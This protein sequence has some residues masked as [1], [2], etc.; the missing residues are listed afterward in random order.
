MNCFLKLFIWYLVYSGHVIIF[1]KAF[2]SQ[3]CRASQNSRIQ[4]IQPVCNMLGAFGGG[5]PGVHSYQRI[6]FAIQKGNV[7][8]LQGTKFSTST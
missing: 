3:S 4:Q 2:S 6:S 8:R 1:I 7:S 5:D